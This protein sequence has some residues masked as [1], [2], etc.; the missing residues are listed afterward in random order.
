LVVVFSTVVVCCTGGATGA[1]V[2]VVTERVVVVVGG[3]P[4][5]QAAKLPIVIRTA[6][7]VLSARIFRDFVS[8]VD[9]SKPSIID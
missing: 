5:S 7:P 8:W 6:N 1:T 2:S 4:L 3:G 9:I